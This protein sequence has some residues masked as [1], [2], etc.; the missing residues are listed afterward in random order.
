MLMKKFAK[1]D[2]KI[3]QLGFGCW[4]IGKTMW[5]GA[6]DAESKKTLHRA[7]EEGINFLIPHWSTEMVTVKLLSEKLRKSQA[8]NY[9]LLPK[10]RL[11]I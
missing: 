5:I 2:I 3:S 10:F 11:K 9:L 8:R 6:D 4:G 7:I 1:T